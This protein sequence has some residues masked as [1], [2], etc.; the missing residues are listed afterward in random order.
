MESDDYSDFD[1]IYNNKFDQNFG[2]SDQGL[3]INI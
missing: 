2:F 1:S 3:K